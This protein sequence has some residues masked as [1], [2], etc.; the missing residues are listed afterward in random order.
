MAHIGD[1]IL[2]QHV[3]IVLLRNVLEHG[4]DPLRPIALALVGG[5]ANI[6][7]LVFNFHL[8]EPG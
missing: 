8:T 3:Q 7:V 4:D 1:K 6:V 2:P 5:V